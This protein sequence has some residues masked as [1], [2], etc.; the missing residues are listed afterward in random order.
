MKIVYLLSILFF[1][2][3]VLGQEVEI[4]WSHTFGGENDDKG[5][6]IQETSDGGFIITGNTFSYSEGD[7][8][9]WLI[10]TDSEGNEEW[11]RVFDQGDDD[12]GHYV[13]QT[14]DGGYIVSGYTKSLTLIIEYV[15]DNGDSENDWECEDSLD[16]CND[17]ENSCIQQFESYWI[18]D[19]WI[20]KTDSYG[21]EEWNK[22][23]GGV[24]D[25]SKEWGRSIQ[26]TQD[27]GYIIS[28]VSFDDGSQNLLLMK[29]DSLGNEEWLR[30]YDN[31]DGRF[32]VETDDGGF[33]V[34]GEVESDEDWSRYILLMKYDV[35][36]NQEWVQTYGS[37]D[38]YEEGQSL[39]KT[40]DGGYIIVG[41]Y[42]DDNN[43]D[44]ILL[45]KTDNNGNQQWLQRFSYGIEER[46]E[47]VYQTHDMGYIITGRSNNDLYILKTD[48]NGN[49]E[50]YDTFGGEGEDEGRSI[51]E[52]DIGEYVISGY[53]EDNTEYDDLWLLKVSTPID[54]CSSNIVGDLNYD[55]VVNVVDIVTLVNC[56][57]FSSGCDLCSDLNQDNQINV[58]DVVGLVNI[59]L[60]INI[61]Q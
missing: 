59:I 55:N 3:I 40:Q 9:L 31:S 58:L 26:Q 1:T 13:Q 54:S 30:Y 7:R 46:G 34:G 23:F 49:E 20:I 28:G 27:G 38:F 53:S 51:I 60:D 44:G 45:L 5:R 42:N 37:I 11:S 32:V 2:N 10:K 12:S 41:I 22:V 4:E 24:S 36:G 25:E 56:I 8:D 29:I 48:I 50:W 61:S 47:S 43:D 17:D 16:L 33:I 21:N 14:N 18:R 35:S 15:C 57:F 19:G 6:V 39:K 52:T